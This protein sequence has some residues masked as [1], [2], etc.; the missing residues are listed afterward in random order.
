MW[1]ASWGPPV[2]DVGCKLRSLSIYGGQAGDLPPRC[3]VQ[4]GRGILSWMW[5]GDQRLKLIPKEAGL[6][7]GTLAEVVRRATANQSSRI[8]N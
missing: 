1:G 3:G 7:Q 2:L 5:G 8:I 4:A 6:P